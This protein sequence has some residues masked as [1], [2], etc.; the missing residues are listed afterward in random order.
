M[1]L[2]VTIVS[3][4]QMSLLCDCD[5][6]GQGQ[7]SPRPGGSW[8]D[9]KHLLYVDRAV[10]VTMIMSAISAGV[11]LQRGRRQ[12]Q[13]G[14]PHFLMAQASGKQM[15]SE[16]E[17]RGPGWGWAFSPD[18]WQSKHQFWVA[19]VRACL[20]IVLSLQSKALDLSRSGDTEE[21]SLGAGTIRLKGP[22]QESSST[23]IG[24]EAYRVMGKLGVGSRW[25]MGLQWK[26]EGDR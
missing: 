11:M 15:L 16:E 6:V 4:I 20:S 18:S 10:V 2:T 12:Q 14:P 25:N 24:S 9:D 21:G 23:F 8:G 5:S 19:G 17:Q 22:K 13:A 1:L 7:S 26:W 3:T